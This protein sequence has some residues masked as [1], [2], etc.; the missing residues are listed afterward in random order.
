MPRTEAPGVAL[1][2]LPRHVLV[3]TRSHAEIVAALRAR[4]PDLECRG[5]A[6]TDVTEEDLAWA[7]TYVG[8]KRPPGAATLGGVH[9][10]HCT[11]AGVDSWLAPPALDAAILLTR[12]PESFG[13]SIAEWAVARIF[14]IQ[15]QLADLAAAQ[16][17]HR[18][19][20]R[21]AS[22][23]AGTR[24]LVVGTG[25][26]GGAIAAALTAVG[27]IVSGVSRSGRAGHPAFRTVHA[28]DTLPTLVG[29]ADWIVLALPD[30]PATRG[31][32][33]RGVM[34]RCRGAVLLNAGRGSVVDE[35][36]LPEALDRGWLRGAALDVFAVEPLPASSPLWDDRR[37][38]ISPHCSGP[39]TVVGAVD[40]FLEC[41][42]ALE[43]RVLPKWT[44]DRA[45]GY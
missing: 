5:A 24:A 31:L 20:P 3:A 8:F 21:D 27:V 38:M 6:H 4:R 39:T 7:D 14:A 36:A 44:V 9:W 28:V 13:P 17:D 22:R 35:A 41:L 15:Q 34:A 10:V 37:V 32:F 29:E 42:E 1:P 16:R 26:V 12:T 2:S 45:R 23:L 43:R 11:G 30:T 18:W 25:D 33:S 19:A 40:G